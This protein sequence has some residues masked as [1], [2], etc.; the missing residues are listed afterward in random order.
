MKII[1]NL[2]KQIFCNFKNFS[3]KPRHVIFN[4]SQLSNN[5]VIFYKFFASYLVVYL[6]NPDN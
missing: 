3:K 6:N 1:L 2:K 5:N 4:L